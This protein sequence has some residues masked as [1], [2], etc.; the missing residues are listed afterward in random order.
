MYTIVRFLLYTL[1]SITMP[2]RKKSFCPKCGLLLQVTYMREGTPAKF[3]YVGYFCLNCK[4]TK[5]TFREKW[6]EETLSESD[7]R[8]K[9]KR[10]AKNYLCCN[11]CSSEIVRAIYHRTNMEGSYSWIK[12]GIICLR[13]GDC[14]VLSDLLFH[15]T[16]MMK[17]FNK[18]LRFLGIVK[19]P[20]LESREAIIF[21]E[22]FE[23]F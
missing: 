3:I 8:V 9:D 15:N 6:G 16:P 17:K 11:G 4:Y 22:D 18:Y 23:A 10:M 20:P 14:I 2:G 19:L 1:L 12:I 13:C 7:K 21:P 5:N